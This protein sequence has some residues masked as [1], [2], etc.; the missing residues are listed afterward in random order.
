[1]E[2]QGSSQPGAAA[3]ALSTPRGQVGAPRRPSLAPAPHRVPRPEATRTFLEVQLRGI[4]RRHGLLLR[5]GLW[6]SVHGGV[7]GVRHADPRESQSP[8]QAADKG[9]CVQMERKCGHMSL[10]CGEGPVGTMRTGHSYGEAGGGMGTRGE[11]LLAR[12]SGTVFTGPPWALA[13][14]HLGARGQ[15]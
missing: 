11:Q 1:M 13:A 8:G 14:V 3:L 15:L 6:V 2:V 7:R 5:P 9:T 12:Q 10:H 4:C